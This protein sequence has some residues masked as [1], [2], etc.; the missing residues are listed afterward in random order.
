MALEFG[1]P[2]CLIDAPRPIRPYSQHVFGV[3][4]L[5]VTT[6]VAPLGR[7]GRLAALKRST[8]A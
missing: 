5:A 7:T 4:S 3:I 1:R 2:A 8:T 6:S